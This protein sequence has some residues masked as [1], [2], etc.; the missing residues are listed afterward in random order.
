M[1]QNKEVQKLVLEFNR[2]KT[3]LRKFHK[4]KRRLHRQINLVTRYDDHKRLNSLP[5]RYMKN[6]IKIS[7][8][9]DKITYISSTLTN[10]F[11][12]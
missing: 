6:N 1:N 10:K 4:T 8:A 12:I 9:L 3:E 2:T 5:T 7:D 11:P